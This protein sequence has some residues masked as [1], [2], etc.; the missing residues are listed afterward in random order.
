MNNDSGTFLA[1]AL[2]LLLD[3]VCMVDARGHF[4]FVSAACERIFGYTPEEMIGRRMLDF[5]APEDIERTQATASAVMAGQV[6]PYFENRYVHKAGHLVH[7]MWSAR[8]S[9]ADQLRIGVARDISARKQAEALQ[10]ATYSISEAAHAAQDL[11]ALFRQV[12]QIVDQLLPAPDFCV[13][14]YDAQRD[15][16]EFP[17]QVDTRAASATPPTAI[18]QEL[19]RTGQ[20]LQLAADDG[21]SWLGAPLVSE[22][23]VIGA[24]VLKSP[25]SAAR[26]CERNRELLQFV[27]AQVA[28]A[29]ERKRLYERLQRM[30]RHDELTGLLN[31]AFLHDRIDSALARARR[32]G[33]RFSLVFLDLDKF[34]QVNDTC[35]H[36]VGDR[37]L[38]EVAQRLLQCVREADSVARIGG[39]EFVLLLET[40]ES[41]ENVDKIAAKLR[42]ELGRPLRI[43]GH[44]LR[45]VPSI[46]VAHYPEHGEQIETLLR[47][48]DAAMYREKRAG[49]TEPSGN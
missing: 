40:I 14:L 49:Q 47:H 42:K 21:H 27:S 18:C 12:H 31:R 10:A 6:Q 22:S 35:G 48:A 32:N 37:L 7:I 11:L 4:V 36:T 26:D 9:E 39:D 2:D 19:V 23:G 8:W 20:P 25:C 41:P 28:T 16:L 45:I 29:I 15:Q 24:L 34:K 46:G 3:A 1:G 17:Y 30:A 44:P 5:V 38:Q 33:G 13:A 43:D